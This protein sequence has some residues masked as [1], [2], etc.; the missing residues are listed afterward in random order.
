MPCRAEGC[1]EPQPNMGWA[2]DREANSKWAHFLEPVRVNEIDRCIADNYIEV[3]QL[4]EFGGHEEPYWHDS[5]DSAYF[6][7]TL[8][9]GIPVYPPL[10]SRIVVRAGGLVRNEGEEYPDQHG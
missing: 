5:M 2:R 8:A 6:E 1:A 10:H 4:Q 9:A 7:R 3:R